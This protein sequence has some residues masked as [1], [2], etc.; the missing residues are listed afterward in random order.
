[1]SA[2][3]P[4]RAPRHETLTLRGLRHRLTWWG[5]RTAD[6]VVLLH[7]WMDTSDTWQFLVDCLPDSWSFAA[8]DWRGFGGSEWSQDGY[9]FADYYGDLEALLDELVPGTA[10]RVIGHSMG[11]NVAA[12][13]GGIRPARLAW[14]A[15]LEGLGL[16][17]S[18]P[19]RAPQ[20]Y[21][22]WL[23]QLQEPPRTRRYDS[24]ERFAT[25]L[26]ARNPRLDR[27]KAEF[28]ARAW[29]RPAGAGVELNA[30]PRHY[31]AGAMLYRRDETEA[32]WRRIQAPLLLMLGELSEFR[33]KLREDGTDAYFRSIFPDVR[34]VTVPGAGHMLHHEQPET[35]ARHITG[36]VAALSAG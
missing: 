8:L 18:S 16:P 28:I 2:Y 30:D 35:T 12:M 29:T 3:R 31:R 10:A 19:E 20:R 21:A 15:N 17:R 7:G 23:D 25:A 33:G 5:E 1:M 36:F 13:Y 24:L 32:C 26:H 22:E 6:P 11:G 14:L 9:W 27:A 34:I 4:R